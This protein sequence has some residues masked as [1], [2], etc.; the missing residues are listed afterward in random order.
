MTEKRPRTSWEL[1]TT[2]PTSTAFV[3]GFD[4][5]PRLT[6]T[7]GKTRASFPYNRLAKLTYRPANKEPPNVIETVELLFDGQPPLWIDGQNLMPLFELLSRHSVESVAPG[8]VPG[9]DHPV[10]LTCEFVAP[11]GPAREGLLLISPV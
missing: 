3:E 4:H 2:A 8:G 10:V 6:V 7:L 5:V 1:L 9:G 11:D